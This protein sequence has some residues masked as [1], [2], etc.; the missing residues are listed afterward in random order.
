[1]MYRR[2]ILKLSG[3]LGLS[4]VLAQQRSLRA[5]SSP[6]RLKILA[7][8][9]DG[10]PLPRK[11]LNQLYFLDLQDEPL[12]TPP[13]S[14]E[15]GVLWSEPP[16]VVPFAIALR[17]PIQGFG[18][19]TLYAD[20]AGRGFTQADFPLNLNVA[21]AQTRFHRVQTALRR[22]QAQGFSF[23]EQTQLRLGRAR[24]AV[25]TAIAA[26]QESA[27]HVL[28][29]QIKLCNESLVESLW[30][31]EELALSKAQQ[32]IAKQPRPKNFRF[33]CNAFGYPKA[34]PDYERYFRQ[35]FNFATVPFYWKP[36]EPEPGKTQFADRDRTVDWLRESGIAVKGHPLAWFHDVGL[37]DWVRQKPYAEI[38]TLL[39]RRIIDIT[40]HYQDRIAYFDVMNEAH[41]AP[42]ANELHFSPQQFLDIT[43]MAVHASQRGNPNV[44]RILN[45]CCAWG[46]TVAYYPPPQQSPFQYLKACIASNVPFEV[47]GIQLYYPDQ[48]LFEID[49]LLDRFSTLGKPIHITELGV[50]SAT[51]IDQQSLLKDAQG[52]WH[53]PWSQNV[54]ADWIEQFYTICYSKPAIEAISWWDFT[55]AGCFW[56]FGGLL[57]QNMQP[58]EA[59]YRLKNLLAQW[60]YR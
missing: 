37:P 29:S 8:L 47:I 51:G 34:G 53:R 2:R 31:G 45:C 43:Q 38:K 36:F 22:W 42:W 26:Y 52:L 28:P 27:H 55:D 19:V 35:I 13:R 54:Q 44:V 1:M 21:F 18:E 56:P 24:L 25:E 16:G 59:F 3:G 11:S 5:A 7:Y 40:A 20:N 30:A 23:A 33:G 60:R 41:G 14:V 39:Q 50:S 58:K 46:E 57:D 10:S 9:P 6:P 49:R 17:L 4:F 12:P 32:R 15:A 48:D